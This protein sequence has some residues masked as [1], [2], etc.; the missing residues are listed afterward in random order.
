[1]HNNRPLILISNDDGYHY[2]GIHTLIDV[3]RRLGDVVVAVPARHQSGMSS[4]I[5]IMDPTICRVMS[6][7]PGLKVWEVQGTPADCVKLALSQL[8]DRRPDV[9]LAGINHGFNTGVSTLYSGTMG[10][11]FEG[12]MH[13]VPAVAYSIGDHRMEAATE[14]CV[15]YIERITR[16]VLEQG[17]P[18]DV[19]LNVNFPPQPPFAGVKVT[20]TDLGRWINEYEHRVNPSGRDYFWMGGEYEQRDP[21]DD[22]TDLYWQRR[23]YVTVTPCHIDQTDHQSM[24]QI[25]QMLL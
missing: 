25:A 17:L 24:A 11:A 2:K 16:R 9:V 3:A 12:L 7:E 18:A 14:A 15:P 21:A 23:N 5:S 4:A 10:A 22:R 19:C 20:K 1:M 13:G 6:E 8:M